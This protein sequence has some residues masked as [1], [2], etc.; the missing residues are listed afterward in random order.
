MDE[1]STAGRTILARPAAT[2][3]KASFVPNATVN[4][5]S[6]TGLRLGPSS[7]LPANLRE[8]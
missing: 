2:C 5:A 8:D 3:G 6:L 7:G 4:H 1:L